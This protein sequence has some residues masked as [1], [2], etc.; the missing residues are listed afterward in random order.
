MSCKDAFVL[1]VIQEK[2][3]PNHY[4]YVIKQMFVCVYSLT[5]STEFLLG[6]GQKKVFS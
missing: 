1:Q 6:E 4:A 3:S 2:L 5:Y